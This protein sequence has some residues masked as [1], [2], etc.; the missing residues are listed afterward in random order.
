MSENKIYKK[1]PVVLQTSAIKNFF[2]STVEQLYSK[3]NV[4]TVNG[5]IGNKTSDDAGIADYIREIG[6]ASG[7]ERVLGAGV[8][9]GGGGGG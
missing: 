8:V 2:E 5:F 7:R 6:R 1:L 9:G 3:S 4:E